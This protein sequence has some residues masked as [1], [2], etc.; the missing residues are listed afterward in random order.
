[1][2]VLRAI[3]T[4]L[5]AVPLGAADLYVAP[6]GDDRADGSRARPLA[7]LEAARD[8]VRRLRASAPSEAVTVWLAGGTYVRSASFVLEAQDSGTSAAPVRY[9][10]LDGD[11]PRLVL[12]QPVPSTAVRVVDDAAVLARLAPA[13]RGQVVR[14]DLAAAGIAP[15][16]PLP[17]LFTDHGGLPQVV[18]ADKRLPIARWPD[19]GYVTIA[20][21]QSGG[22][23]ADKPPVFTYRGDRAQRWTTALAQEGVWV[24][25]F[26]R[27]PWVRQIVR[28]QGID[29]ARQQ[30]TLAAPVPGGIGSKYSKEVD[31]TRVGDGKEPWFVFNLLEELDAPG[32]W[33]ADPANG[34]IYC[35]PPAPLTSGNLRIDAITAPVVSINAAQHV[36]LSNLTIA[37][38]LG[39]GIRIDGGAGVIVRSCRIQTVGAVG[40]RVNGGS[41]HQVRGCDIADS[42]AEGLI[43]TAGERAALTAGAGELVNNHV[44]HYGA[45]A[46]MVS[47]I[48]VGGVGNRVA[49]NLL[50]DGPYGGVLFTGNDHVLEHNEVHHIGLDGGDLGAFYSNGDWASRGNRIR[51]NL[52]HHAPNANAFYVDDGK[53]GDHIHDNLVYAAACGPFIG[54]GHHHQVRNNLMIA[55]TKGMHIDD[56]GV[57]RRYDRTARHLMRELERLP[58]TTPPWSERYPELAQMFTEDRLTLP[59]GNELRGNVLI[60]CGKPVNW[61]GRREHFDHLVHADSTII[62]EL[63]PFTHADRLDFRLPAGTT[64]PPLLSAWPFARA[65]L[66]RDA[67]RSQLPDDTATGRFTPRPPRQLF[68]SQT[69]V[70]GTPTKAR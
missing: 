65:G 62:A 52:V 19:D 16:K 31:G 49:H 48:V 58:T 14:I 60:A 30:I 2:N 36:V 44:H 9:Q 59:T 24:G 7:S 22:S 63:P 29:P 51:F 13:A 11:T 55:C 12:S 50:H 57:A 53:S 70:D 33:C 15:L 25:A 34:V 21:V 23:Q 35:W 26:W 66:Q 69:D 61:S 40:I 64:S 5:I 20:S 38:G 8:A 43:L 37:G 68:D 46:P 56:R 54:G 39:D 4:L 3:T 28:V 17:K 41:G 45:I 42:G 18:F 47:G 32:E 10:A 6:Q 27:V 67:D 1:M